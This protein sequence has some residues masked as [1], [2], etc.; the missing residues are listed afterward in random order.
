MVWRQAAGQDAGA[1]LD[2]LGAGNI[3]SPVWTR[4]R[5]HTESSSTV[6][7]DHGK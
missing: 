4:F 7:V 6:P 3:R 1:A 5:A 2:G